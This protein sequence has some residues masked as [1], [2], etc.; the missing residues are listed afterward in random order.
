MPFLSKAFTEVVDLYRKDM[1]GAQK[2]LQRWEFCADTTQMFFGHLMSS[3]LF[4]EQEQSYSL[5]R[6]GVVQRMFAGVRDSV[7]EFVINSRAY[8]YYSRQAAFE[9]LRTMT[10]Q[11]GTPDILLDRKFLKI[12]Y[13]DLS[14]QKTDF[15]QN[16]QYGITFLRR[17]EEHE[18]V[19]PGEETR[20]LRN[21][22][23]DTVTFVPSANKVVIP[24]YLLRPPLF[25]P[26]YPYNVNL[27]GLGV[28]IAEAVV[29]GVAGLGSVFT[30][31]GEKFG[32]KFDGECQV[33]LHFRSDSGWSGVLQLHAQPSGRTQLP[34][35]ETVELP[36]EQVVPAEAG[37]S[38]PSRQVLH[39]E[40]RV[41]GRALRRLLRQRGDLRP[42]RRHPS[43]RPGDARPP[44]SLLPAAR[45]VPLLQPHP[46]A[47]GPGQGRPLT[48]A[49]GREAEGRTLT[50]CSVPTFQLLP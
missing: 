46:P 28:M 24:E 6:A 16:M 12:M 35:G 31:S 34:P 48:P 10:I 36:G 44:G 39:Q 33:W 4:R 41:R 38:G 43:P 11:V 42:G 40:R 27:G 29:E 32:E 23:L 17:R 14:V 8:D 37:H 50:V 9:K 13:K 25:H 2:P 3:L 47:E 5:N 49:G 18:L 22:L 45:P 21:L 1:I 30:A 26:Q 15:F 7:R 20:W 19:S